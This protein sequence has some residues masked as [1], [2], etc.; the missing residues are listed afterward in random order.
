MNSIPFV[1]FT[2]RNND[3]SERTLATFEEFFTSNWYVLG[4]KTK[5]F[6]QAYATFNRTQHCIGVST[7][8]DALRLGLEALNIGPGDEV[9]VPSN[10][11]IATVLA[12]THVGATPVFVEPLRETANLDPAKIAAAIT[13]KTK[14]VMPVH[15][16]GQACEMDAIMKV[17]R[18]HD[19]YV[20]EDNAQAQGSTYQGKLT[21]SFGQVNATSFYPTK[22]LG[23]LGEAGA[24]TTDDDAIAEK[25]R[26][27]SNYGSSVTYYNDY[28]GYNNRIDEFEAAFLHQSLHFLEKWTLERREIDRVYRS[29]LAKIPD[30][31]LCRLA[32]GA[33]TVGHLFVIF[34][35][36]RDELQSYLNEQG[37]GTKIHYPVPPHL[38][39][40]YRDLGYQVGDFPIAEELANTCLSL[41]IY[42]GLTH[43]QVA[44]VCEVVGNFFLKLDTNNIN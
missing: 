13:G 22:N 6:E 18:E 1:D 26:A 20:V 9:I 35:K 40:C 36:Q 44:R 2:A 31:R 25:I 23:A 30:I 34:T 33:T 21:G 12:V 32:E 37:I 27:L 11:Y 38:Q 3:V 7:G 42:P 5:E 39:V 43:E 10:T 15:L 19:L 16:Y 14:A 41:P 4:T 28:V 8:L 29:R 17:A 24:V